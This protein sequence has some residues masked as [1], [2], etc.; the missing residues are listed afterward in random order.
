MS[1][2]ATCMYEVVV[3]RRLFISVFAVRVMNMVLGYRDEIGPRRYVVIIVLIR[4]ILP[5][6]NKLA[7]AF[8]LFI[9]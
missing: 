1:V 5:I 4:Y 6:E 7:F 9:M 2:I 8:G 3:C